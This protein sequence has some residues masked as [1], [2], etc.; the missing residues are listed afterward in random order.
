LK[1]TNKYQKSPINKSTEPTKEEQMEEEE[2]E[3]EE[4]DDDWNDMDDGATITSKYLLLV[5]A[6]FS[7]LLQFTRKITYCFESSVY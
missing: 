7:C 4:D 1:N 5:K 2:E 6:K 3:G